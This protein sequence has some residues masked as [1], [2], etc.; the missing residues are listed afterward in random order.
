MP[1]TFF[2]MPVFSGYRPGTN[3]RRAM[4]FTVL[5]GGACL[6]LTI[7][8]LNTGG[9]SNQNATLSSEGSVSVP[10]NMDVEVVFP[11]PFAAPPTLTIHAWHSD[12]EIRLV[13]EKLFRIHNK[14]TSKPRSVEWAARGLRPMKPSPMPEY[15][16]YPNQPESPS[17][18][19]KESPPPAN[20]A[21]TPAVQLG[22]P[23]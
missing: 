3:T 7:G 21:P 13:T 23:K 5:C 12:W 18:E 15:R 6:C 20:N 10:P 11:A 19:V 8:C 4:M 2:S 14:N 1:I 16:I 17:A 9:T 22:Q